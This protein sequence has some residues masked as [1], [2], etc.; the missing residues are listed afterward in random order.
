[1]AIIN[2]TAEMTAIESRAVRNSN[3]AYLGDKVNTIEADK[4]DKSGGT[5][6]GDLE[7][8]GAFDVGSF[9]DIAN[10]KTQLG[11]G[12][13]IWPV[14]GGTG[15]WSAGDI[16]VPE[17]NNYIL[18]Y[19]KM[20]GQSTVVPV[21]REG[22]RIRGV[23]GYSSATPTITIYQFAATLS[24]TTLTFVACNSM[25]HTPSGSHSAVGNNVVEAIIGII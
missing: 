3:A 15:S 4:L 5:V 23:G 2:E 25:T 18:Y 6:T 22:S 9:S 1:M 19:I 11:I 10:I 7:V 13:Q 21:I 8:T 20:T 16:S 12:K 24:G 14:G 17:I